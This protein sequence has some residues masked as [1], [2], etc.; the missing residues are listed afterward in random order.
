MLHALLIALATLSQAPVE[1]SAPSPS[2][3]PMLAAPGAAPSGA[4]AAPQAETQLAEQLQ[5]VAVQAR[6]TGT[7]A[8]DDSLKPFQATLKK[9]PFDKFDLVYQHEQAAPYGVPT[10]FP[11]NDQYSVEAALRGSNSQGMVDLEV[12]V[13]LQQGQQSLVAL[14]AAGSVPRSRPVILRG[15]EL[16]EG[17]LLIFLTL[18]Q[19]DQQQKKD[20]QQQ[21]QQQ[22]DQQE[23]QNEQDDKDKKQDQTQEQQDDQQQQMAQNQAN[24]EK[25]QEEQE[26]EAKEPS[27]EQMQNIEAILESLR[28]VDR[29]EQ[30]SQAANR[31]ERVVVS[32]D[33]W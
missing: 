3:P 25:E 33:W 1:P 16:P 5:V 26:Q 19:S 10:V 13:K 7:P 20:Q 9:L 21:Q 31:R 14:R 18:K 12:Q 4:P 29:K 11:I 22:Q 24:P 23:Q 17:E 6:Q 28:E 30:K 2:P 32:G 15:L 27:Q 8:M